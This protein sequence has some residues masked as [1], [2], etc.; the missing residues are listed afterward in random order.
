MLDA[1]SSA[2]PGRWK[3]DRTPYLRDVMDTFCDPEIEEIIMCCGSQLGKTESE[4]NMIGYIIDQNPAPTLVVYPSE[5]LAEFSSENRI[6]PMIERCPTLRERY[7][8]RSSDRMEL[9]FAGMYVAF[10][11]ANSPS[12]LASRPVKYVFFDEIDKYPK[13]SGKEAS[14]ISLGEERT[15]TFYDRKIVKVSTPTVES[16]NI[17]QAY[18]A[19]DVKKKFHVPCPHC[20]H[21][22]VLVMKHIKWPEELNNDPQKVRDAAYYECE[23]C[24]EHIH[25]R[26]K[27]DMLRRGEWRVEDESSARARS[28]G[29]Q[30]SSIY[31]PW[32]TFG[33][34][35]AQ[36]LK[37]KD[38]PELLM[39]FVN[40]WLGEPWVEK[41]NKTN[42]DMVLEK[43]YTNERG[44]VP[45][46]ALILTASAD[47]Q[48][49]HFWYEVRAWGEKI[50]GWLVEYGRVETWDELQ[51]VLI[52]RS[53]PCKETGEVFFVS[54]ACID[55]GYNTDEVYEF[56][57][58]YP[59]ICRPVK[60]SSKP[61]RAPYTVSNVDKD[62]FGG[63]KLW[64]VD[65]TYFKNFIHGR[66]RKQPTEPG[67]WT[68]FKDCPREY[69]EQICA[70]QKVLVR[71]RSTGQVSEE[72][73]KVSSHAQNH[74]LDC[75]VYTAAAADMMGIRYLTK[76]EPVQQSAEPSKKR[77]SNGFL[78]RNSSWLRR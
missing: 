26:H 30:L 41:T 23:N 60:G 6:Q 22:Q 35:A 47:V 56:C 69:A 42:A 38:F 72:W 45:E 43:Q 59:E 57:S 64:I 1:K 31:S 44:M 10:G 5:E 46:D 19:A 3:T 61:L 33:D 8:E 66:V 36:F 65:T 58:I 50:T 51:E 7:D 62:G 68:L 40:S 70:E 74:L 49:G 29:Y 28:I 18:L 75:A 78:K 14:P 71:N 9:Q 63:L 25:D 15:K 54:L 13:F 32:L 48:K 16:G 2:E 34:V 27:A 77:E 21:Y 67:A 53:Y 37:S 12:K 4:Q 17:W 52:D 24:H 55:A 20:G 39:N 73:Q 11:S 76:P